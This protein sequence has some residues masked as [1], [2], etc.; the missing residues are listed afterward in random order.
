MIERPPCII[1]LGQTTYAKAFIVNELFS[2]AI[3]PVVI[4]ELME[5]GS[6]TTAPRWRQVHFKYGAK[7]NVSLC[8]PG[9]YEL[10]ENLA[11]Y[12]QTWRTV[13]LE[14][15]ELNENERQHDRAMSSASM[16]VSLNHPLLKDGV[17]VIM[18]SD[19]TSERHD[20]SG[21]PAAD[22][23]VETVKKC[24]AGVLPIFMYAINY[25]RLD[26]QVMNE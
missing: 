16:E 22:D 21:G 4:D 12:N 17:S 25:D 1:V 10:V 9:S 15:I 2:Q 11:A 5:S 23:I 6:T 3:L 19:M 8:L 18:T 13:P 14:D 24:V 26:D 20:G 7:S